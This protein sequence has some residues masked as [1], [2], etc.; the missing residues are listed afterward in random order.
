MLAELVTLQTSDGLTHYGALYPPAGFGRRDLA[1]VM[2]HGMTGSFI[3]EIESA[4]PPM[5]A[6]AGYPCLVANNRGH[7]FYG[8]AT[9]RIAG[10]LPDVGAAMD[11][12]AGRGFERIALVGHSRGGIKV[13]YYMAQR[14]NPRV[15]ALGLLSPADSVHSS[16]RQLGPPFGGK[17]WLSRVQA[18]V[19][20]GRG[21]TLLTC[22]EWPYMSSAA[23]LLDS[24][25]AQGDDVSENLKS[26]RVPVFAACGEKELDWC[27]VV[28]RLVAGPLPGYTVYVIPGADHVYTGEEAELARRLIAWL[29]SIAGREQAGRARNSRSAPTDSQSC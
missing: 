28:A 20:E 21:D 25:Q 16:A 22:S 5:L 23:S 9:E 1:V 19:A 14:D 4:L 17:R 26:I 10:F 7:G 3:G 27:T 6:R 15:V 2:V 8:T 29:D 13:T 24:Y 18:L 12:M 11:F